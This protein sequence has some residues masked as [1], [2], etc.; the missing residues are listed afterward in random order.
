MCPEPRPRPPT[1]WPFLPIRP[2]PGLTN[3]FPARTSVT[4]Y[5][6]IHLTFEL[7]E[8]RHFKAPTANALVGQLPWW[9]RTWAGPGACHQPGAVDRRELRCG[10]FTRRLDTGIRIR[11]LQLEPGDNQW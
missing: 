1:W 5:S 3:V 4:F 9:S 10:L 11:H 8:T 7:D 6:F 2:L